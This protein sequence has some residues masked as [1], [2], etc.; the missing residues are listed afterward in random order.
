MEVF[1]T[2]PIDTQL[3]ILQYNPS[4]RK[5][6]NLYNLYSNDI[7]YNRNCKDISKGEILNYI[8]NYKPKEFIIF[9]DEHDNYYIDYYTILT[10]G[11]TLQYQVIIYGIYYDEYGQK[12]YILVNDDLMTIDIDWMI[13][14]YTAKEEYNPK[15][16]VDPKT[17]YDISQTRTTCKS[18]N[19]IY[20]KDFLQY[21]LD[22]I[23]Q[24]TE[25]IS[26][27]DPLTRF[28]K[29]KKILYMFF[30]INLYQNIVINEDMF[31][32]FFGQFYTPNVI[33][34]LYNS[35]YNEFITIVNF[36]NF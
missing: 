23:L 12:F 5:L 4:F 20:N 16:Y 6:S 27:N 8:I 30:V 2:L 34:K 10:N 35:I 36:T 15:L 24:Q 17:A 18:I 1:G 26:T 32:D 28:Q 31:S 29:F 14:R 9:N 21:Y 33:G 13:D 22:S 7:Y 3:E 19:L 25:T 11:L